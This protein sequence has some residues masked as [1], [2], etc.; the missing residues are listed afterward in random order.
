MPHVTLQNKVRIVVA[1]ACLVGATFAA[2]W[3]AF[4]PGH[5][6]NTG[7]ATS[8]D[9]SAEGAPDVFLYLNKGRVSSYLAQFQGG[10]ARLETLSRQAARS[11]NASIA[12]NGIGVGATASEQSSAQLSLQVTD[13][14][15]FRN[16]LGRLQNHD[17]TVSL[18]RKHLTQCPKKTVNWKKQHRESSTVFFYSVDMS[19][20]DRDKS[21]RDRRV[22]C[23]FA[24][25]G[26]GSFVQLTSCQLAIP[27]YAQA[28]R[29]WRAAQ[30]RINV[31]SVLV[32]G[33][34]QTT[35]E[36]KAAYR[37]FKDRENA[38]RSS[39]IAYPVRPRPPNVTI[40]PRKLQQARAEMNHLVRH[41]GPNPRVPVS[42]C[43]PGGYDPN[44]PDLMMPIGLAELTSS[45]A[46]LHGYVTVVGKVMLVL[47][48][49]KSDY[50]DVASLQQWSQALLWTSGKWGGTD[51]RD[52]ATVLGP[53][54]V[55]QPIA[56]YK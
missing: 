26:A 36:Q 56:I 44:V 2:C 7:A 15:A 23:Q 33:P 8:F 41:A 28:E 52:D 43:S 51:L 19:P 12:S 34:N 1:A 18:Q 22:R 47:H 16:L 40:S 48:G 50:V 31:K 32:T 45:P 49:E 55:I 6:G 9:V 20:R 30:G 38:Q 11:E 37:A 42:S 35:L 10:R 54:Y 39:H 27:R 29:V 53:G 13:Q 21:S 17:G 4:G 5:T 14:A 25:V 3:L 46:A 24:P